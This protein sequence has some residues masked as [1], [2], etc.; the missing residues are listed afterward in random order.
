[1]DELKA[2]VQAVRL[3]KGGGK[4]TIRLDVGD[5]RGFAN[6]T[7]VH[8][9][10]YKGKEKTDLVSWLDDGEPIELKAIEDAVDLSGSRTHCRA[11]DGD[12]C[13]CYADI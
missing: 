11:C 8:G 3:K 10:N 12:F 7:P 1:M 13:F 9:W 4:V 6:G 5:S 2:L